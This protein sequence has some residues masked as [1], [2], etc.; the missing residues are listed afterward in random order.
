MHYHPALLKEA[1]ASCTD[2]QVLRPL[3]RT[4][5]AAGKPL[6]LAALDLTQGMQMK[7]TDR[8]AAHQHAVQGL[9]GSQ[10]APVGCSLPAR[11]HVIQPKLVSD[12]SCVV[13]AGPRRR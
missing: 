9:G 7:V 2:L 11:G 10:Q 5:A 1:G 8:P 4:R 6:Q 13:C 3:C 12:L